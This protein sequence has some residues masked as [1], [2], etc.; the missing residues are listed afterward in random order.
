MKKIL[1]M[2]SLMLG[3]LVFTSC[4]NDEVVNEEVVSANRFITS[5]MDESVKKELMNYADSIITEEMSLLTR[6]VAG[7]T[8]INEEEC[9]QK[10]LPYINE[11]KR[12]QQR[13]LNDMIANPQ[14]YPIGSGQELMAMTDAQLA[15]LAFTIDEY[16]YNK[17]VIVPYG[18]TPPWINCLKAAFGLNEIYAV[19]DI[20]TGTKS[21]MTA[22]TAFRIAKCFL[23]RSLG[24]ASIL[25]ATYE[26]GECMKSSK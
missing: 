11:G 17:N 1:L 23:K 8:V 5:Q 6:A 3:V 12:I 16:D 22:T 4:S 25:Y 9:R 24:W 18:A 20:I 10:L 14:D 21:L 15:E 13:I 7:E 2:M 19:V 26:Y